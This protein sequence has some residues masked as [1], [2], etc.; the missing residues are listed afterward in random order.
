[1][2]TYRALLTQATVSPFG[3]TA[4][5]L[6]NSL[7][8]EIDWTRTSQ[9]SFRGTLSGAFTLDKTYVS[10]HGVFDEQGLGLVHHRTSDADFVEV[11]VINNDGEQID[12][13]LNKS[14]IEIFVY[15]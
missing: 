9:G 13:E 3:I 8:G 1:M 5:V 12:G 11:V 2:R 7:L 4:I 15:P 10:P 6:E 14:P